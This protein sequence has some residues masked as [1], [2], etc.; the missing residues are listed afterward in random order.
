MREKLTKAYVDRVT[1]SAARLEV[2][3]TQCKGLYLRVEP[4]GRKVYLV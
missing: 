4:R 3:D 1:P 2:W